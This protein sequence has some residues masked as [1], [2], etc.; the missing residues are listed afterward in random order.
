MCTDRLVNIIMHKQVRV[1]YRS[2]FKKG[3]FLALSM[4]GAAEF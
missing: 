2:L 1:R 4:Q 3:A